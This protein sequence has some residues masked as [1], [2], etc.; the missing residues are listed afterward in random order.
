MYLPK[1]FEISDISE[2]S[3]FVTSVGAADLVTVDG[4]MP[5]AT[6]MPC[7]WLRDET[8]YGTLVMHMSRG[9]Q[10]WKSVTD[11]SIGLAIVHGPQ[12]YISPTNYEGKQTHHKVVPTWNYQSVHFTGKVEVSENLDLLRQIVTDLT[13]SHEKGREVPWHVAESDETYFEA[14]LKGIIAVTLHIEKIE[15]KYKLSQNRSLLDQNAVISDLNKSEKS[16]ERDIAE[17]MKRNL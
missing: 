1:Q 4:G 3:R 17:E 12:A 16:D 5:I 9:N 8:G 6:L 14:Q 10:Q 13:D 11:S 7:V 2:I 15:A